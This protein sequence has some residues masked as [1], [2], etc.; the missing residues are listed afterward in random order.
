VGEPVDL[1]DRPAITTGPPK[2]LSLPDRPLE[3]LTGRVTPLEVGS[4][5]EDS[6]LA[7]GGFHDGQKRR[8]RD[9]CAWLEGPASSVF[10]AT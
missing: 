10:C 8:R 1:P 4:Q 3:Y 5:I 2:E 6:V 9:E 7:P